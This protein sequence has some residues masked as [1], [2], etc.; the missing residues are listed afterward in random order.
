M[1]MQWFVVQAKPRQESTAKEQL[2]RQGYAA[3]LP[4]IAVRKRRRVAWTTSVEPLFPRYL[5]IH[6]DVN[7]QSLAPVRST[8]GVSG[9]VRFGNVLRPVPDAVVHYL[10]ELEAVQ[11]AEPGEESWP[12]RAGDKVV[13]LEGAFAGL[14]AVFEGGQPEARALI[15]IEL[16]GRKNTVEVPINAL[17]AL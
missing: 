15:L 12:F 16:L 1:S 5:F 10:Q 9:L 4:M 13:V 2:Q 7:Q 11:G 8:L 14:T 6:A 17:N 3:Y